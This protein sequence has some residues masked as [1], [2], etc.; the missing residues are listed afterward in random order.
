MSENNAKQK[1]AGKNNATQ[2]TQPK[3]NKANGIRQNKPLMG[4]L[5]LVALILLA[6]LGVGL[7]YAID[8]ATQSEGNENVAEQTDSN[9]EDS[10]EAENA[11]SDDEATE[12]DSDDS[13]DSENEQNESNT[14]SDEVEEDGEGNIDANHAESTTATGHSEE[15]S[16]KSVA[17]QNR[18]KSSG[19]WEATDYAFGDIT[20]PRYTVQ[21]GDTLWEISEGYYGDGFAWT[22]IL[23]L[24]EEHIGTLPNGERALIVPGTVL[25]LR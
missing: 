5:I 8:N 24:N 12:D 16:V 3:P 18:I 25:N 21:S 2:P 19:V 22:S 23:D 4:V 15:G 6:A 7:Y 10:S 20:S 13:E 11:D 14:D 17:N 1:A 9:N